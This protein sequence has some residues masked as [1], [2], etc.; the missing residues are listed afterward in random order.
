[1]SFFR[2]MSRLYLLKWLFGDKNGSLDRCLPKNKVGRVFCEFAILNWLF[3]DKHHYGDSHHEGTHNDIFGNGHNTQGD[4]FD[5]NDLYHTP[6]SY[7]DFLNEQDDYDIMD[8][9]F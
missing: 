2:F 4:L 1:M 5:N 9:D 3:G 8:D 7:D 6:T